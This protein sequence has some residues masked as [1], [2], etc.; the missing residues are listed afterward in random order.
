MKMA[1]L[2]LVAI[3]VGL[4]TG[5]S[6][7]KAERQAAMKKRFATFDS[8]FVADIADANRD[9]TRLIYEQLH[10]F[11]NNIMS[12][13]LPLTNFEAATN[14][15]NAAVFN[16]AEKTLITI[17]YIEEVCE[18]KRSR[19]TNEMLLSK[20]N[21][22]Y[23]NTMPVAEDQPSND[24]AHT[25]IALGNSVMDKRMKGDI[26]KAQLDILA[27]ALAQTNTPPLTEE[28]I[29]RQRKEARMAEIERQRRASVIQLAQR[30][31][32]EA[33]KRGMVS[34]SGTVFQ[35]VNGGMLFSAG[36]PIYQNIF[37]EDC[38]LT[39][40]SDGS[41]MNAPELYPIGSYHYAS[42]SGGT[43][44]VKRFTVSLDRAVQWHKDNP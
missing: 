21:C 24:I 33:V 35:I 26:L 17:K 12:L 34:T 8:N 16:G 13:H 22:F 4:L 32:Q 6:N 3:T 23:T 44:T 40:L 7:E 11:S 39:G 18:W 37:I 19:I 43:Q 31:E 42:V 27:Q 15:L 14:Q 2:I 9:E 29:Q 10:D 25:V 1:A 5:C 30:R 28:D 20:L 38:A 41:P 36:S